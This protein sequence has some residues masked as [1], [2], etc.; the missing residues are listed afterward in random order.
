MKLPTIAICVCVL[1]ASG[2]AASAAPVFFTDEA[3]FQQA[4]ATAGISLKLDSFEDLPQGFNNGPLLRDGYLFNSPENRT[5][6]GALPQD[7]TDGTKN[8]LIDSQRQPAMFEFDAAIQAFAIDVRDALNILGGDFVLSL[9]GASPVT[10]V[11]GT[12][13]SRQLNFVGVIDLA[14]I[15]NV[16]LDSTDLVDF[17]SLDRAQYGVAEAPEPAASALIGGGLGLLCLF[18]WRRRRPRTPFG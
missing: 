15:S 11:S 16:T 12:Q 1:L 4:V 18:S 2:M 8:L 3:A 13:S 7:G 6:V 17:F 14:G 9:D 10:L 5:F